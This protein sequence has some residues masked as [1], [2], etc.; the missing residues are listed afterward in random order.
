MSLKRSG[1]QI[2]VEAALRSYKNFANTRRC[3]DVNIM[4]FERSGRQMDAETMLCA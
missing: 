4:S 2:D 3:F 1:R